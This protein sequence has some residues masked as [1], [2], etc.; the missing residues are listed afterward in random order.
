MVE[1]YAD[2]GDAGQMP[3]PA[4]SD[5]GLHCLPITLLGVSRL[6]MGYQTEQ[7]CNL[8]WVFIV[9]VCPENGMT[10]LVVL[11]RILS[12]CKLVYVICI[13]M[14]CHNTHTVN[15][16][17]F[18]TLYSIPFLPKVCCFLCSYFL[19]YLLERQSV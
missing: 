4:A 1:P 10:Y 19:N 15:I 9:H 7:S 5:L 16:L 12:L 8:I 18:L 14:L 6:T 3:H 2:S 11:M 13:P 17:K